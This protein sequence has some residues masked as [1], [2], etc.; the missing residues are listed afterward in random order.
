[1][2]VFHLLMA[3]SLNLFSSVAQYIIHRYPAAIPSLMLSNSF[4][5][6]IHVV[7]S[8]SRLNLLFFGVVC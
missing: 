8:V 5:A 3:H 2:N 7:A 6:R 4:A 1:M